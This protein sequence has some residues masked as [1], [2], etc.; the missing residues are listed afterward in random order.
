VCGARA[1]SLCS[2]LFVNGSEYSRSTGEKP[3]LSL[4]CIYLVSPGALLL[5]LLR[6]LLIFAAAAARAPPPPLPLFFLGGGVPKENRLQRRGWRLDKRRGM[7]GAFKL[8]IVWI[9]SSL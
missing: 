5:L 7:L 1:C 4:S 6:Q 9:E 8:D 3:I 2:L